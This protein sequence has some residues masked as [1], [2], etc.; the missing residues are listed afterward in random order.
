MSMGN[1]FFC[2]SVANVELIVWQYQ[3]K[4]VTLHGN[5]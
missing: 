1:I 3:T 5:K 2:C 4:F